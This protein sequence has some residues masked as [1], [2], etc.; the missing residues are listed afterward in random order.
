MS[1]YQKQNLEICEKKT[2][3]FTKRYL[4]SSIHHQT[5]KTFLSWQLRS[6]LR[7]FCLF[8]AQQLTKNC[9]IP[10]NFH[11]PFVGKQSLQNS[12]NVVTSLSKTG[13]K[14][15]SLQCKKKTTFQ[16]QSPKF[17]KPFFIWTHDVKV[18]LFPFKTYFF[19]HFR[20]V[21]PFKNSSFTTLFLC[22]VS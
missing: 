19:R 16:L 6:A 15:F 13:N 11:I 18:C 14:T 4:F 12:K 7:W 9:K 17:F 20:G 21:F 22:L 3:K 5:E 10:N 2:P 1:F 8:M